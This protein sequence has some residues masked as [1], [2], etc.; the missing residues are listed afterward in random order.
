[1]NCCRQIKLTRRAF[2]KSTLF[3]P[4]SAAL[5]A[6]AARSARGTRNRPNILYLMT[7]QHRG[8]CLG[9]AGNLV[10][11]TP[12]LDSIA[13]E[14]VVFSS[15]YSSTP[16]CTPARSAI[17]TGLSP[18]HHGMIGYG[19]IAGKYRFE[20][21][22]AL[23]DA[24]YYVY[25]IG[26]M[27]WFPQRRLRG[28]HKILLDESGRVQ[29]PGFIS[30]YR[31]WFK[32]QTPD[33]DPDATGIGWNDYRSKAY[34]LPQ[35]LHPTAWTADRA[36][37]FIEKYDG[38]E[39]FMLKVSF[40]RPHS[41]YDPPQRFIDMYDED[42]MPA[43]VVGD[44]AARYG[45]HDDPPKPILWHGDLGA[46]QA[47]E[48]RRAY[49]GS[50]TFIDEQI[51]RILAA[52]KKSGMYENTLI[53]MFSDHGDMLGDHHLWRKTYAYEGSA[54]I[55]MLLRW[56]GSMGMD[57][58]RG[59]T[60]TQ[61]AE[62]RDVLPTFLDAAGIP[63]PNH[64]DGRSLLELVRGNTKDWRPFIDLEHSM[65]YNKD[66][67][68]ALTDGRFKYI[69]Y[70]FDGREELFD[71]AGDPGEL[72]DLAA[73]PAHK[74]TLLEWRRRMVEHL[75]ERGEPFVSGGKLAVRKERLLYS[76]HFPK[77]T[78]DS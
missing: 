53:I 69:Y 75:S 15:A 35:R 10:I 42:D 76:P 26:K 18:W 4:A 28:Y 19:R 41:P 20:L 60:L 22:Q 39:P 40:A 14:G 17:L 23:R 63:I 65:C 27:H 43:P 61:P 62:L 13:K 9:C 21:P 72:H 59:K 11:K 52:L 29:S 36:V 33:L 1:M 25:G 31:Q 58:Q 51:G 8:D 56:P 70:A 54:K 7:D 38:S 66:H 71:L 16:S 24:G 2:L 77:E 48:S 57:H 45:P 68:N 3:V 47:R 30:D 50:I 34:A 44:W 32:E 6:D 5:A 67:W 49:Y 55:P 64:L 37:D 73:E 46:H 78:A 74:N 12:H